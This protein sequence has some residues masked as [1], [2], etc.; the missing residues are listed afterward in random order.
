MRYEENRLDE[1]EALC[2]EVLPLL[3]VQSTVENVVHRV[4]DAV[5]DQ[6]EQWPA[7]MKRFS[8]STISHSMLE[9]GSVR[10]L[11][12]SSVRG[13]DSAVAVAGQSATRPSGGVGVWIAASR[14]VG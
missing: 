2:T 6:G 9:S 8:C 12:C 13:E 11:S 3:C 14:A 1:A 5:A 7:C 10:A 4:C